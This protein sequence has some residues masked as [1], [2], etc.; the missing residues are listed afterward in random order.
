MTSATADQLWCSCLR[1]SFY[2]HLVV[3][4]SHPFVR[5][6]RPGA[7]ALMYTKKRK[8]KTRKLTAFSIK[9]TKTQT[10]KQKVKERSSG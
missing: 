5:L 2:S 3:R 8:R 10:N 6:Y 4:R 1:S 9:K 7:Y